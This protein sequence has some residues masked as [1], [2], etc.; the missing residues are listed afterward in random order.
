[1]SQEIRVQLNG[2]M[3]VANLLLETELDAGQRWQ[4]EYIYDSAEE[5]LTTIHNI[6]DL[7]K[8]ET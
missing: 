7:A 2:I 4:S 8:I 1:M 5:L 3:G 6:H